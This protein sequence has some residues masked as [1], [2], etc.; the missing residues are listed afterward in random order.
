MIFYILRWYLTVF[1]FR[2]F[3][4]CIKVVFLYELKCICKLEMEEWSEE[5]VCIDEKVCK[6]DG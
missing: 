5:C 4:I 6:F 3:S 2:V 1:G